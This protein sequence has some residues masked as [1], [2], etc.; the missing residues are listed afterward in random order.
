MKIFYLNTI[1]YLFLYR[2]NAIQ[3]KKII[4]KICKQNTSLQCNKNIDISNT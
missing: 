4:E 2:K 1:K 3:I